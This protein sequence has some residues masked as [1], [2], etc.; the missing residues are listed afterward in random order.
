MKFGTMLKQRDIVLIPVPFTDLTA[1]K[2]RPVLVLSSTEFNAT[3]EDIIVAAITSN[4]ERTTRG[5]VIEQTDSEFAP[6]QYCAG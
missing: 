4:L 1:N 5:R 3:E 2:R 6:P